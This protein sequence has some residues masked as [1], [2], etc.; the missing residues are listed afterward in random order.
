MLL[1]NTVKLDAFTGLT[2]SI[3]KMIDDLTKEKEDEIK[4]KDWCIEE[5]ANNAHETALND[6][7]KEFLS[8]KSDDLKS[9]MDTLEAEIDAL[10]GEVA[11]MQLQMKKA[12]EDRAL[13]NKEFQQTVSD[14]RVT[15]KI[16]T[17]A[18]DV[19]KGFYGIQVT[20]AGG[21]KA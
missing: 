20:G 17:S 12:G 3:Q 19:L 16:L 6:K 13:E 21:K 8:A 2:D 4:L 11:D 5:F 14:Q 1:A 15:Q 7:D 18:L 10:R 9:T